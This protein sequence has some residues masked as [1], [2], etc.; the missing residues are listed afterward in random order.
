MKSIR[1]SLIVYFLCLL[2]LA[3]FFISAI[4]F[5]TSH[6]SLLVKKTIEEARLRER[7]TNRNNMERDKLDTSLTQQ[8]QYLANLVRSPWA[9]NQYRQL[10]VLGILSAGL[11]PQGHAQVP[12]WLAEVTPTPLA[13]EIFR[14]T[15]PIIPI[16][17]AS[18]FPL[19]ML[20]TGGSPRSLFLTHLWTDRDTL[21]WDLIR[22]GSIRATFRDELFP[23]NA[24][25]QDSPYCQ[26]VG[27]S[28]EIWQRSRSLEDRSLELPA[29]LTAKVLRFDDMQLRPGVTV[30]VLTYKVPMP[31]YFRP[32]PW[33]RRGRGPAP[34]PR[35]GAAGA[36]G[37]RTEQSPAGVAPGAG[38][39][40]ITARARPGASQNAFFYIQLARDTGPRD[41]AL[42]QFRAEQD[43]DL[44]RLDK[45]LASS[46][47]TLLNH[48]LRISL[49]TFGAT[50]LGGFWI[51]RLGLSPLQRLT[52]AV[53]KVSAKDFRLPLSDERL[54]SELKPIVARLTKT[55][56]LLKRA[57]AREKQAAADI[58]HELRTPLSALL[59]TIEVALRKPRSPEEYRELLA[60][61]Q[62]SGKQMSQ[63]V[64]RLLALARLDAGVDNVRPSEVD[65]TELAE[66][67][68]AL[69][70]PLVD[71]RGLRLRVH[72]DG[73]AP[74]N[75]DPDKLREIITNLLHNAIEYNCPNG[76]IDLVVQRDNGDLRVE[77]RD[78]GIGISAAAREH[79]FERFYRAD[80]S[81][82][83][84]GLHAGLGLAIVKGY[85]DIM[86][87]TIDVVSAEGQGSTFRVQFPAPAHGPPAVKSDRPLAGSKN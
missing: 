53:S 17:D 52:E 15:S 34:G 47:A 74:L 78:T 13:F 28:G 21:Q 16:N 44:A 56:D 73:P 86:G 5:Q 82:Q 84:D 49:F 58:S 35:A 38:R 70:R 43:K 76:A 20:C 65:V 24:G 57:F 33:P 31:G 2:G 10:H 32:R 27:A 45:E 54:P 63:L 7:F 22:E 26:V 1:L 8:V 71:A 62:V 25:G 50:V 30:R 83:A 40:P 41:A 48:L 9:L 42:A 36:G 19:E 77:V 4:V 11:S 87:G 81:R 80:P 3:L 6:E 72:G 37:R 29:D 79:I 51:V 39:I 85:I 55:L 23:G 12:A 14:S 46:D 68:A 64:E 67:C 75:T 69:V 60:D 59:T 18:F 66:Q 61:C